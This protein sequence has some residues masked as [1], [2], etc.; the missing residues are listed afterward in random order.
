MS[1]TYLTRQ[2]LLKK[3]QLNLSEESWEEFIYFYK[4]F[5]YSIIKTMGINETDADDIYQQ[6][7]VRIWKSIKNFNAKQ[8]KGS[9]RSWIYK[10]TQNTTL[11]FIAKSSTKKSKMA[12]IQ[13][14]VEDKVHSPEIDQIID[15]QWNRHISKM[16]FKNIA[17]RISE[18]ALEA[19]TSQFNGETPED[20]ARRLGLEKR[21]IYIY[22][23][24]IK[25]KLMAE[26]SNLKEMLE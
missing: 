14:D 4:N 23:A 21:T 17:E 24:R 2:T 5:I 22:R 19:F 7:L 25:Q 18:K 13:L 11:T 10:I 20:T 6:V 16:A 8:K 1:D 12:E 15:E 3:L 9:F 26:I